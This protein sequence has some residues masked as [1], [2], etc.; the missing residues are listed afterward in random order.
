MAAPANRPNSRVASAGAYNDGTA[1]DPPAVFQ[2]RAPG[3]GQGA[4]HEADGILV[5]EHTFSS[6]C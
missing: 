5:L 4:S 6:I 2:G 1:A 3:G